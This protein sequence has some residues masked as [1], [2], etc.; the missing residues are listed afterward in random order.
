MNMHF[1]WKSVHHQV[2]QFAKHKSTLIANNSL[3]ERK[4]SHPLQ[5]EHLTHFVLCLH[6]HKNYITQGKPG[7][8]D[9]IA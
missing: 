6:E 3:E 4:Q 2:V 9:A 7:N 8:F 5:N 1:F